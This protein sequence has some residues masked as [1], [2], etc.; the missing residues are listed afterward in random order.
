MKINTL[1]ELGKNG[2]EI[3]DELKRI[4]ESGEELDIADMPTTPLEILLYGAREAVSAD[5]KYIRDRKVDGIKR[6]QKEG[7]YS[8]KKHKHV[9]M[10]KFYLN[11]ALWH[12]GEITKKE[13]ADECG[14]TVVTLNKFIK[15]MGLWDSHGVGRPP[16]KPPK[17]M[18]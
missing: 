7:K 8:G 2:I 16:K 12:D 6:A 17:K 3:V 5:R 4:L 15:D 1:S 18:R 9:P 11:N 14:V 13:F 10:T